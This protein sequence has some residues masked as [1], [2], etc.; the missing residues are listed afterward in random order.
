MCPGTG[1]KDGVSC[2]MAMLSSLLTTTTTRGAM[3][4]VVHPSLPFG[5][6]NFTRWLSVTCWPTLTGWPGS[7]LATAGT[8][9]L[10]MEKYVFGSAGNIT[11]YICAIAPIWKS[12][13]VVVNPF[14]NDCRIKMTGLALP[15]TVTDPPNLC[16]SI[17]IRL[18]ETDGCVSTD[19]VRS[20][21]L[22]EQTADLIERH[23][24][25]IGLIYHKRLYM[26]CFNCDISCLCSLI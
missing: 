25:I 5:T 17:L 18:V 10:W 14:L 20:S 3:V 4:L 19:G 8:D 26:K 24:F 9:T 22:T 2:P 7:C 11:R 23:W 21:E 1:E 16:P 13:Y 6:P 15:A 12:F